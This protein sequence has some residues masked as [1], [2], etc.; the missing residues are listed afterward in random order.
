MR[1]AKAVEVRVYTVHSD[2]N[3][4]NRSHCTLT[5]YAVLL[6]TAQPTSCRHA[7]RDAAVS[8]LNRLYHARP[9]EAGG[10]S[11]TANQL[12]L[13]GLLKC[14][15]FHTRTLMY[16]HSLPDASPSSA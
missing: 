7:Q 13:I 11:V 10:G 9:S 5:R 15:A 4:F 1:V 3:R 8:G 6:W 2:L 16:K 14:S 12:S